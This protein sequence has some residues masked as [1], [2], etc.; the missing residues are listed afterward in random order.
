M[1]R[2]IKSK[3]QIYELLD[4]ANGYLWTAMEINEQLVLLRVQQAIERRPELENLLSPI[5]D[6]IHERRDVILRAKA[7]VS[8]AKSLVKNG[9]P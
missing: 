6:E 9:N 1:P 2:S 3:K 4:L 8:A 5:C 7:A